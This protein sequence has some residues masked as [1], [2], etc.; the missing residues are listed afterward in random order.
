MVIKPP[1]ENRSHV[2]RYR[3]VVGLSDTV[4][5]YSDEHCC[6]NWTACIVHGGALKISDVCGVSAVDWEGVV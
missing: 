5:H 4:H 6:C 3:T 1:Q 2:I